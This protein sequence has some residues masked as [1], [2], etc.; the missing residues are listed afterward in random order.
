MS[1][2]YHTWLRL[3]LL[4]EMHQNGKWLAY[5]RGFSFTHSYSHSHTQTNGDWLPCESINQLVRRT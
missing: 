4:C 2:S 1:S 5:N 3:L